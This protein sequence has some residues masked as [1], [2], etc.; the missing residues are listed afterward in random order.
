[1]RFRG[2][3]SPIVLLLLATAATFA[4]AVGLQ[5]ASCVDGDCTR[6]LGDV[7]K[8]YVN[9]GV[10]PD[11]PPYLERMVEYPVVTGAAIY[12][13]SF[14]GDSP[15]TF[16]LAI[17]ALNG[18]LALAVT[19]M[20]GRAA[21]SRAWRWALAPPLALYGA[22]NWDLLAIAPLVAALL[23]FERRRDGT[24]GALLAVGASAKLF[25]GVVVP[26]LIALRLAR[27]DRDGAKR[28]FA[29]AAITGVLLNLPVMLADFD[30]WM[31]PLRFHG[32]RRP[33]WA[34]LMHWV[35]R[36][37]VVRDVV[38][39]DLVRAGLV[40]SVAGLVVAVVYLTLQAARRRP[41]AIG[42]AA[43]ATA[44]F[45]LVAKVHSPGYDLWLVPF[46]VLLPLARWHYVAFCASDLGVYVLTYGMLDDQISR[47]LVPLLGVFAV[48]RAALI[49]LVAWRGLRTY[50]D[51]DR[52]IDLSGRERAAT[53]AGPVPTGAGT[54]G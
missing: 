44:L 36:L 2:G 46:F 24:A 32:E 9:R 52:V 37:P 48:A 54:R 33:T 47:R 43:A 53:P 23:A 39:G 3:A 10:R 50:D 35:F 28:L 7:A 51:S 49:A 8:V 22:H 41:S 40:V 12:A 14:A 31:S 18:A 19:V 11:A 30:G 42:L 20:L 6:G 16:L 29:G 4:V 5:L 27:G 21:P 34:S 25:P 26:P 38:G 15:T 1:M 45:L 13:A 17:A